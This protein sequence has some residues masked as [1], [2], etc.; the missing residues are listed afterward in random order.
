MPEQNR[1]VTIL[2]KRDG[3]TKK[4]AEQLVKDTR[5]EMYAAIED[6]LDLTDVDDIIATNLGLEPDYLFDVLS[7]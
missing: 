5:D 6:G 1:V 3:I 4:E 7:M 2:M